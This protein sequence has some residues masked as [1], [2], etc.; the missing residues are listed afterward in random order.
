MSIMTRQSI[1]KEVLSDRGSNFLFSVM[2]ETYR[3]LGMSHSR[4]A[5]YRPQSNG[6]V[7][8]LYQTLLQMIRK[9][10]VDKHEWDDMLPFLLFACREAPC[11]TTGFS[12]FEPI[13]RKKVRG[14]LDVLCQ[15]WMPTATT[16][17]FATD[18]LLQLREDLEDMQMVA[19]EKQEEILLRTKRWFDKTNRDIQI[20][21]K[22]LI[23]TPDIFSSKKG[24]DDTWTGSYEVFC[25]ILPVTYA[26]DRYDHGEKNA[27]VLDCN[28]KV[29]A[30]DCRYFI[31]LPPSL[32]S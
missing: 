2:R 31:S 21:D 10:I 6:L 20:G 23:F 29:D 22:V 11:S 18:W 25:K 32:D 5:A 12:P 28:E 8:R 1:P 27:T 13:F 16:T 14:P 15:E 17:R 7:E 9:T 30:S 3:F 26:I 19:T 24:M 4:T